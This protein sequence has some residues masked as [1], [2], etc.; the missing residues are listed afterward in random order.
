MLKYYIKYC[1]VKCVN[2]LCLRADTTAVCEHLA[3]TNDW[4]PIYPD[5]VHNIPSIT[6]CGVEGGAQNAAVSSSH[7]TS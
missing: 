2:S 1:I 3:L 5:T 7:E 4:P 6:L